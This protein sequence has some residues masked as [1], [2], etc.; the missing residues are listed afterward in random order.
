[1]LNVIALYLLFLYLISK[2]VNNTNDNLIISILI[3]VVICLAGGFWYYCA[4]MLALSGINVLG[5]LALTAF[6]IFLGI[7]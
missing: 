4:E 3:I 7:E 1:M 2:A 5:F 6:P